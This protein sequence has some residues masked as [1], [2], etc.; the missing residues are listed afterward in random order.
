MTP[1]VC[2]DPVVGEWYESHGLR[3]EVVALDETDQVIEI[4]HADG[5]LEEIE[6][7]DWLARCRAGSL[8][9]AGQPDDEQIDGDEDQPPFFPAAMEE[10]QGLHA[11]TTEDL[12]LF[13]SGDGD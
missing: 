11:S 7:E 5:A 9:A 13:A 2:I 4:Q 8:V 1:S 12:D 6:V 10:L 3:F